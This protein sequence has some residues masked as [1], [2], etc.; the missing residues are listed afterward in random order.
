MEYEF[1][2]QMGEFYGV[3]FIRLW[4]MN[5]INRWVNFTVCF[6]ICL[7][8]MNFRWQMNEFYGVFFICLWGMNFRQEMDEFYS[9]FFYPFT[10][11]EFLMENI[12]ILR[13][14]FY[15]FTRYSE[16][17]LVPLVS[18]T[19]PVKTPSL[20]Q[21]MANCLGIHFLFIPK[22]ALMAADKRK[23]SGG[24]APN[25][26]NWWTL[27]DLLPHPISGSWAYFS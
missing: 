19:G 7:Q 21:K 20:L 17:E 15:L 18:S 23:W 6:F 25:K 8:G 11:Y 24:K 14:V 2:K 27:L 9:V 4:G 16:C 10:G 5:F 26:W 22:D 3:F 12:W 13:C 1:Q